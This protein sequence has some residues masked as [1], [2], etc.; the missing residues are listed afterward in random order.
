MQLEKTK[1]YQFNAGQVWELAK[2]IDPV[3]LQNPMKIAIQQALSE[4]DDILEQIKT[5]VRNKAMET[6]N[7]TLLKL[8]EMSPEHWGIA[9]ESV[10]KRTEKKNSVTKG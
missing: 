3:G 6:A 2:R 7:R 4:I 5:H 10:K 8:Q 1:K 9:G